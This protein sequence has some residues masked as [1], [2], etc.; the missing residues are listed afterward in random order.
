MTS[1]SNAISLKPG[2]PALSGTILWTAAGLLAIANF[3]AVLD[4][5][6]AN[7]SVPNISGNL[8]VASSQGLWV[9]TSYAVAEAITVPL[10]GWL[11]GRFGAL[12]VFVTAMFAFG[13]NS[14]LC[15]LAP[16]FEALVFFRVLQ[17]FSGGP[18]MPLS[19]TLLL[20]IF[21]KKQQPAA[22]A[23]WSVTTL[24]APVLGPILGGTL[25]D[26]YGWPSIFF[27]NV[28]IALT[29]APLI[30]WLLR[31]K[32]TPTVK[33]RVDGIGLV[34]LVVWVGALQVMLDIGKDRDWFESPTIVVLA[35]VALIG[36]A[37]FLIWELTDAKPIVPLKVFRHRGFTLSM[38][39][40]S[41]A[42]G[43]FFGNNV[44]TPLWLQTNM[45]YTATWAGYVSG[46]IGIL[47]IVSAP[48][49]AKLS[50]KIDPRWLICTGILWL[51]L[52]V[53]LRSQSNS[54]MDYWQIATWVFLA[55]AGLPMFFLPVTQMALASVDPEETAGA[56]GLLNFIRTL[57]SAFATS[58]VNTAWENGA[59]FNQSE[60]VG[61]MNGTED[62]ISGLMQGGMQQG[63]AQEVINNIVHGQSVMLATNQVFVA[64][65]VL[66]VVA[67]TA[68]WLAPK[69]SRVADTSM[70]H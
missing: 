43:A 20:H 5:T 37:A 49:A 14:A 54:D 22:L 67:A 42:F 15:G 31:S 60:I 46:T 29:C 44:I 8:G 7:V 68:I 12:R 19:Q 36:F 25:C 6:I 53:F 48:L 55:G 61:V 65:A 16:S 56:A 64:C 33:T 30:W 2:A 34:L 70:A 39:T 13:V 1:Q 58:I 38:V 28:P 47:A 4:M 50:T 35:I 69:P 32:E 17:G 62:T 63:Q 10:T 23:L 27:V 9:I 26:D 45:G 59:T 41:L 21:P 66:F 57:S 24:V 52:T 11:A 40:M 3:L 18:L 51:G